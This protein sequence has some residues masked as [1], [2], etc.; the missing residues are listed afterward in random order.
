MSK[1]NQIERASRQLRGNALLHK[2]PLLNGEIDAATALRVNNPAL[3]KYITELDED[4]VDSV[5]KSI[6][7]I[8]EPTAGE[9]IF[10]EDGLRA[11]IGY[12]RAKAVEGNFLALYQAQA[13]ALMNKLFTPTAPPLH[14]LSYSRV[15]IFSNQMD[16]ERFAKVVKSQLEGVVEYDEIDGLKISFMQVVAIVVRWP[17]CGTLRGLINNILVAIDQVTNGMLFSV[18]RLSGVPRRS[19]E[20]FVQVILQLCNVGMVYVYGVNSD[21]VRAPSSNPVFSFLVQIQ[22][23]T[24]IPVQ[25]SGSV[26]LLNHLRG[27]PAAA[28]EL[29]HKKPLGISAFSEGESGRVALAYHE[30]LPFEIQEALHPETIR[31]ILE[32]SAFQRRFYVDA[33]VGVV[34]DLME[35]GPTS[36]EKQL[37]VADK[38]LDRYLAAIK[39][40][41]EAHEGKIIPQE[42]AMKYKESLPISTRVAGREEKLSS[43]S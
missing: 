9:L 43:Y 18:S 27:Q 10:F 39:V 40:I 7:L 41:K 25:V 30:S 20:A 5:E 29:L 33:L 12:L 31:R 36:P 32:K 42:Y 2:H 38:V 35:V 4:V 1:D 26:A 24:G 34:D 37:E 6:R 17:N 16:E 14:A 19:P 22:S 23:A 8:F 15:A 13:A 3:G 28:D 11:I 21:N